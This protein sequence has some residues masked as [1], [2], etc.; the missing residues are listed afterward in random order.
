MVEARVCG[1][2]ESSAAA[3]R[4]EP[5]A[6]FD[7]MMWRERLGAEISRARVMAKTLHGALYRVHAA[8]PRLPVWA[9]RPACTIFISM[10]SETDCAARSVY[11]QWLAVAALIFHTAGGGSSQEERR[12][13]RAAGSRSAQRA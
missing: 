3:I 5:S 8:R 9:P 7:A 6:K 12:R 10:E 2:M 4:S 1:L 11:R 13:R